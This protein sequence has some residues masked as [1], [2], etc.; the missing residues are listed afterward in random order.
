MEQ[1]RGLFSKPSS[2]SHHCRGKPSPKLD[3]SPCPEWTR[4]PGGQSG[5][6]AGESVGQSPVMDWRTMN[7]DFWKNAK[8]LQCCTSVVA[9]NQRKWDNCQLL[10]RGRAQRGDGAV[11]TPALS[12]WAGLSAPMGRGRGGVLFVR[13]REKERGTSG[14]EERRE[15]KPE[16]SPERESERK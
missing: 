14:G 10:I 4:D 11:S 16:R 1:E 12:V 8:M 9:V 7:Q 3:C 5:H 6:G 13:V 2:S 15:T